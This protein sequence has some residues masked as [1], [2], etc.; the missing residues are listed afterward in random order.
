[1]AVALRCRSRVLRRNC[2][3]LGFS[4]AIRWRV[5][6]A[7][8]GLASGLAAR[9]A[10]DGMMT[11]ERAGQVSSVTAVRMPVPGGLASAAATAARAEPRRV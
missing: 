9:M 3:G 2:R 1:M 5:A 6:A 11:K 7:V 4:R 8:Q 10:K